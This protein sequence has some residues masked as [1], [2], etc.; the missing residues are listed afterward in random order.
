MQRFSIS[1]IRRSPY[2]FF[3][4]LH[5]T[6]KIK[7]PPKST[8]EDSILASFNH[9]KRTIS[10]IAHGLVPKSIAL[11]QATESTTKYRYRKLSTEVSTIHSQVK[12]HDC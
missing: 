7:T 2:D 11:S 1:K 5:S 6:N 12:M 8:G 4:F 9:T 3:K 10:S